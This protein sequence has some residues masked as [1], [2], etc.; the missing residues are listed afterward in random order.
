[1]SSNQPHDFEDNPAGL[2]ELNKFTS[3]LKAN[4]QVK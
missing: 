1:M 3:T 4:E 2:A